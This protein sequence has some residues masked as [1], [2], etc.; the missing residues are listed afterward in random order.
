M[1]R[2]LTAFE[3]AELAYNQAIQ[4]LPLCDFAAAEAKLNE[5]IRHIHQH[6]AD[7]FVNEAG[8]DA[9]QRYAA[10]IRNSILSAQVYVQL[11]KALDEQ[12]KTNEAIEATVMLGK[13]DI[14]QYGRQVSQP[15]CFEL[16]TTYL[17]IVELHLSNA[18]YEA[19]RYQ[20][21]RRVLEKAEAFITNHAINE[22]SMSLVEMDMMYRLYGLKLTFAKTHLADL[23]HPELL[24]TEYAAFGD[25]NRIKGNYAVAE[26]CMLKAIKGMTSF[27]ETDVD[28]FDHFTQLFARLRSLYP[29]NTL[30]YRIYDFAALAYRT[31][32]AIL[33]FDT[34]FRSVAEAKETYRNLVTEL[35]QEQ[36]NFN[37]SREQLH[38]VKI[39]I[40]VLNVINRTRR[41]PAR[42]HNEFFR[43][44]HEYQSQDDSVNLASDND[45]AKTLLEDL[46]F[47]ESQHHML[48]EFSLSAKDIPMIG[49]LTQLD[50][51]I[52]KI[53]AAEEELNALYAAEE[54]DLPTLSNAPASL[55]SQSPTS[56]QEN[57][58][59][60][61]HSPTLNRRGSDE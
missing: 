55:F 53:A 22:D 28:D 36:E 12:Y 5:A 47:F 13:L 26:D 17:D 29:E 31:H 33:P 20:T 50:I 48:Q 2:Q 8:L 45:F 3:Q 21:L 9:E 56:T 32:E 1:Q 61:Q 43:A 7:M 15:A 19:N 34:G 11:I 51:D 23:D 41:N 40:V 57:E 10:C 49:A 60:H 52:N 59:T 24:Y 30:S 58:S 54:N 44:F 4:L 14:H 37:M 46:D 35:K 27:A 16:A 38:A 42:P 6:L 39:M 25:I 18:V